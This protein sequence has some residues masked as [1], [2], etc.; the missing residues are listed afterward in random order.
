MVLPVPWHPTAIPG[1]S[2]PENAKKLWGGTVNWR[3]ATSYDA[4]IAIAKALETSN[5]R[6]ELQ[7]TLHNPNFYAHGATGNIQFLP[8]G[9]RKHESIKLV[10]I[11]RNSKFS[12]GYDFAPINEGVLRQ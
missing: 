10:K 4:V 1:N 8:S 9:D 12:S 7:K 2:F 3:T 6:K 5:N 11:Q